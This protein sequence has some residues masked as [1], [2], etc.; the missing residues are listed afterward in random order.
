[1]QGK[2]RCEIFFLRTGQIL[3]YQIDLN[4]INPI[5]CYNFYYKIPFV[6][7]RSDSC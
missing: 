5:P 7:T 6:N 1:M 2:K 4:C 3:I